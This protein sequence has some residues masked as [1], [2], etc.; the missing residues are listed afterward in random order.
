M[1]R[2][3]N[4]LKAKHIDRQVCQSHPVLLAIIVQSEDFLCS[5]HSKKMEIGIKQPCWL[6]VFKALWAQHGE[7][8]ILENVSLMNPLV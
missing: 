5:L 4:M 3:K 1:A 6:P 7:K 8:A 2:P